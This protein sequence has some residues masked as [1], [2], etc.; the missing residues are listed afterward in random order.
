MCWGSTCFCLIQI[1]LWNS[2]NRERS[3]SAPGRSRFSQ[4][5]V[6]QAHH[7]ENFR[8]PTVPNNTRRDTHKTRK[9]LFSNSK[10]QKPKFLFYFR[11]IT[12]CQKPK[13]RLLNVAKRSI[14]DDNNF[15]SGR[16]LLKTNCVKPKRYP[17]CFPQMLREH[18]TA[19]S[20][21]GFF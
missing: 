11:K 12:K 9:P 17:R 19:S 13:R 5:R 15:E 20:L 1:V 2:T 3:K 10:L 6:L 8:R 16:D 14:P 7:F 18:S 4:S 21:I